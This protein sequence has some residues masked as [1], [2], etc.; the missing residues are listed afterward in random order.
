M[1]EQID[2]LKNALRGVLDLI[3]QR[4]EPLS[5]ELKVMLAQVIEHVANRIQ[6]LRSEESGQEGEDQTPIQAPSENINPGR[7]SSNIYSFGYD[8][9]SGELY[10]KFQGDYPHTNGPVYKYNGV[11][12][13]IFELFKVGAIPA[14]TKGKNKW[15]HWWPGKVPSLGASMHE[16]IKKGGYQY[17]RVS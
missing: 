15:G 10:V 6:Q 4:Q 7:D 2:Q 9:D 13:E 11:P 1:N 5:E 12:Q 14:K 17:Q 8:D 16:L 3:A